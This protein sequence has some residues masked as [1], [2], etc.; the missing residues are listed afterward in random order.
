MERLLEEYRSAVSR[1]KGQAE[2]FKERLEIALTD[3]AAVQQE[4]EDLR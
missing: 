3:R 4:L 2:S 1:A